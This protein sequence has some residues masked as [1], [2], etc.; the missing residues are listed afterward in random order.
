MAD[1][2]AA[3]GGSASAYAADLEHPEQCAPLVEKV[4]ADHGRI[5]ILVNNAGIGMVRPS[6]AITV[7]E[8]TRAITVDLTAPFLCA[9]AAGRRMLAAGGGVIIN[10]GSVFGRLGM[11]QRAAYCAA[12]HGLQGVTKALAAEW[13]PQGVRVLQ[14]DPGFV[15]TEFIQESMDRGRF[16]PEDVVGRTPA[17]RMAQ[18]EE[19]ARVVAFLASGD[20][21]YMTG[22]SVVVDGGW[23]AYGGW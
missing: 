8:W 5:D 11:P 7:E 12:K 19:V 18:P 14:V 17:A 10:I 1:E 21:A 15:Q 2:I 4:A 9:Q 6:V 13:A 16:S 23:T 22:A 3:A 20:A